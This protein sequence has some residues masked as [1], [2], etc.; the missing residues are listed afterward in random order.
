MQRQI[1]QQR[2]E[3]TRQQIGSPHHSFV[4]QNS[5]NLN[6]LD[7]VAPILDSN[8]ASILKAVGLGGQTSRHTL[9]G[10][11]GGTSRNHRPMKSQQQI[12]VSAHDV[13]SHQT[14]NLTATGADGSMIRIHGSNQGVNN[15][16][17]KGWPLVGM[18]H[19]RTGLVRPQKPAMQSPQSFHQL[20]FQQQQYALQ[21]QQSIASVSTSDFEGT[22]LKMLL[23]NQNTSIGKDGQSNSVGDIIFGDG[24]TVQA[25]LP[26]LS[27]SDIETLMKQQM[28]N[29]NEQQHPQRTLLGRQLSL[30]ASM[31][32][33]SRGI[34]QAPKNQS[35]QKRKQ[36]MSYSG[37]ATSS[38]S[39]NT[40]GPSLS[41]APSTPSTHTIDVISLP[42][43][44]QN[45]ASSKASCLLGNGSVAAI[46]SANQLANMDCFLDNGS[47]DDNVESF[48]S[49]DDADPGE[50][51]TFSEIGSI[52]T[53]AVDCCDFSSDG[54]LLVTGGND[55]KAKLWYTDSREQK[56]ILEEHF[57]SI[58][59]TRF[60][61]TMPWLATSSLDKIVR[62][63][64]VENPGNS[65]RTFSGHSAPVISLDFHPKKGD[66]IC[67]CD[68][69]SEIRYWSVK[70][71]GCA[72]VSKGGA[73]Q[74]RF[75]PSLGRFLAAVVGGGVSIV[76]VQTA[77][78]CGN[79]LMVHAPNVQS[80]C[81]DSSGERLA[82]VHDDS[83]R[84][85]KVGSG[86]ERK[87]IHELTITG[88]RF[89]SCIFHP[90]YCSLLVIGCYESL[91]LWNMTEN[92]MMTRMGEPISA[93]AL[94]DT[95]GLVA[96]ASRNNLVKIWK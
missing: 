89:R 25:S 8:Y 47:F 22:K 12:L 68:E 73:S 66:L 19:F 23:N 51:F 17:L 54:K 82:S 41:S 86:A 60:S 4:R 42:T 50:G 93:L 76:D 92:K 71:G 61:P 34:D 64:D 59:D 58:T 36:P 9:H 7:A 14:A 46:V 48:L 35:R 79:Q 52:H 29:S 11:P 80:V 72:G 33:T 74:V 91:E 95:A 56:A 67:S 84:I 13:N 63:W 96:S 57:H 75:Q 90:R 10:A 85:W 37:H 18:D 1:Q 32:N 21:T 24:S 77:Q 20:Q 16:P 43:F 69:V 26:V 45:D 5:P 55:K 81:W 94:S 88:K 65:I 62:V 49:S 2:E 40:T 28:Q 39:A 78:T 70:S 87:C 83:V 15:V 6:S 44:P 53:S 38:V 3:E 27:I 31:S 30:D